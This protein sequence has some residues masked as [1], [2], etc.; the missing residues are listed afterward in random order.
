MGNNVVCM[1]L[2]VLNF[3]MPMAE[4]NKTYITLVPK[5]NN[6]A[7]MTEFRPISL[8]NVIYKLISK[9]LANRLKLILPQIISENQSAF[10][11]WWG[12]LEANVLISFELMHYLDH[13]RDSKDCYIAIKLDMSKAYDRVEWG[14]MEQVM[15][16][17]DFH[18]KWV[19]LI[20]RCI[21]TVSYFVLI[22]GVAHGNIIPSRGP[23][24]GDPLSSYLFL[25]CV[26]GFSSLINK[27]IRN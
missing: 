4:I 12:P 22:N 3:D 25:L 15:K 8:S 9:V 23:H 14:F 1:I 10:I 13:K 21:T 6:P 19:G 7:K 20:M 16:K 27:A 18:E 5:T 26:D 2:N 24:Q 17:L 11:P